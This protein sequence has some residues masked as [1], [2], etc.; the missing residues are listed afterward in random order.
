MK[1]K[2]LKRSEK[3]RLH[4]LM[5]KKRLLSQNSWM[6]KLQRCFNPGASIIVESLKSGREMILDQAEIAIMML[7]D[8]NELGNFLEA[9]NHSDLDSRTIW[10]VPLIKS[11]RKL[12]CAEIRR[13]SI[14]PRW[15]LVVDISKANGCLRSREVVC[16][17]FNW[18]PVAT[19]KFPVLTSMIASPQLRMM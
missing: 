3:C 9:Y 13:K 17:E 1:M 10:K 11:L 19:A 6:K 12:I 2:L 18:W 15:G 8:S 7:E 5:L 16:F 4:Q 14:I